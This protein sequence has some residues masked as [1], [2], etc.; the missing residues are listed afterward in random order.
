MKVLT[1]KHPY[2]TLICEGIK[3]IENRIWKNEKV[4]FFYVHSSKEIDNNFQKILFNDHVNL[5]VFYDFNKNIMKGKDGEILSIQEEGENIYF[6]LENEQYRLEYNFLKKYCSFS[7]KNNL[8]KLFPASTIM[9]IVSIKSIVRDSKEKFAEL[10][11]YNYILEDAK[12]LENPI[13]NVKGKLMFWDYG[14]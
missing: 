10:N 5:P 11:C 12:Y 3:K 4:R 7:N 9:G 13:S 1:I 14:G 8:D 6:N 2:A